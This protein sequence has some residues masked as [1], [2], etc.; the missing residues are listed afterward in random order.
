MI[1]PTRAPMRPHKT[2]QL[3]WMKEEQEREPGWL[4]G[5]A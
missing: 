5:L 4:Q 3:H 1:E 2:A